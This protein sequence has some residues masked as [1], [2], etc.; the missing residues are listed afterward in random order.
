[1]VVSDSSRIFVDSDSSRS[2]CGP[3]MANSMLGSVFAT[4]YVSPTTPSARST[5]SV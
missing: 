2:R 5:I 4:V 3:R 1:M